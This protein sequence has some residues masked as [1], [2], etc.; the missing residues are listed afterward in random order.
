[1]P[2]GTPC[3]HAGELHPKVCETLGLPARSV[4]FQVLLGP[5]IAATDGVIVSAEAVSGQVLAK[6]DFAFVVDTSVLAG[7]L[8]ALVRRAGGELVEEAHVFDVY[9]GAQ[10]GEGKK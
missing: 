2:D 9:A 7:D 3:A 8:E 6:E 10:V 4:A 1:L 5:I